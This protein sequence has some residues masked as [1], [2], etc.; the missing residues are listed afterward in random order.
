MDDETFLIRLRDNIKKKYPNACKF[1]ELREKDPVVEKYLKA[2]E[3]NQLKSL[4]D[5]TQAK[6]TFEIVLIECSVIL[7]RRVQCILEQQKKIKQQK[8]AQE[9]TKKSN[10]TPKSNPFG[11]EVLRR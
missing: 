11:A 10:P 5:N 8:A 9:Q 7:S 6:L 1:F 2:W 3:D 4:Q